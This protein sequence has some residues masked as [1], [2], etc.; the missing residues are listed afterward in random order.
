MLRRGFAHVSLAALLSAS[1]ASEEQALVL[2]LPQL[3]TCNGASPPR[4][5]ERWRATYLMAPHTKSQLVLGEILVDPALPAMRVRL[6]G[7]KS[8][9]ADL[10]VLGTNTYALAAEGSA[11]KSCRGLGDTG[12]RPLGRDWL[13]PSS[14]CVGS[15][16]VGGTAVEWWKT[17]IEPVP[18]S[19]WVWHKTSDGSPFRLVFPFASDRL[20]PLSRYALSYQVGFE[21]LSETNLSHLAEICRRAKPPSAGGGARA[22]RRLVEGMAQARERADDEF[23]RLMPALKTCSAAPLPE[24]PE[25]LAITGLM[26]PI[27]SDEDPYPAEVL[28]DWHRR[29]QRSRIFFPPQSAIAVQDSLLLDPQGYMVTRRRKGGLTCEPVLPGAIRPH[30]PSRAPCSCEATIN[31]TTPLTPHG[32]TRILACPLASPRVAWAWHAFSGRPTVFMVTSMP[33]DEGKGLFAVLD[34]QDWLPGHP[35]PRSALEKPLQCP[36]APP[37]RSAMPP[38]SSR[39]STCHIG[40]ADSRE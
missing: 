4:L 32:T 2:P 38:A 13:T 19:Y 29:A 40:P 30:W 37:S 31:G 27:D 18:A 8:G 14:R 3:A 20:P 11:I 15:G 22:V 28:Y 39:C 12:W 33:G 9:S 34:Y 1:A 6:Y 26:T 36:P 24:W 25:R 21:P 17:P 16:P 35:F 7:F 23:R 5:P 10:L